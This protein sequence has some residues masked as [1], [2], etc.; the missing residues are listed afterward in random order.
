MVFK[1]YYSDPGNNADGF[2]FVG[3]DGSSVGEQNHP[4]SSPADGIIETGIIAYPISQGCG[5]SQPRSN[6]VKVWVNYGTSHQSKSVTIP[7][8]CPTS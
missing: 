2:G 8:V 1:I 3:V 5:T 4:F 6:H 7:L